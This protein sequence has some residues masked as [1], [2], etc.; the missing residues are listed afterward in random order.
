MDDIFWLIM[1]FPILWPFFAKWKWDTSFTYAEMLINML[2]VVALAGS[3][4]LLGHYSQLADTEI[5]SSEVVKK[6]MEQQQCPS[7]WVSYPDNFCT[8]YDTR[9]VKTGETCTTDSKGNRSCTPT[10]STEYNYDY[11][12]ERKWWVFTRAQWTYQIRRID[13][14][15]AKEPARWT[16]VTVGDPVARTMPY[17]NYIQAASD[18]LFASSKQL[19][20]QYKNKIPKQPIVYDYYKVD[21]IQAVGVSIPELKKWNRDLSIIQREL[22]PKKQANVNI[23]FTSVQSPNFMPALKAAWEGFEKNDIVITVGVKDDK[24]TWVDVDSWSKQDMVNVVLRDNILALGNVNMP[25]ILGHVKTDVIAHYQRRPMA[26]FEYLKE[27]IDPPLWSIIVAVLLAF[28]GSPALTWYFSRPQVDI[29]FPFEKK[30]S[31]YRR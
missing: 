24:I 14:Q 7:G 12:W 22:G 6:Q 4:W 11:D 5:Q 3:L 10:Y 9:Q 15:G 13:L 28:I 18:S 27:E 21:R 19:H 8:E 16:S 30:R 2:V 31:R 1:L 29:R 17:N 25:A 23:I 26:E 20:D